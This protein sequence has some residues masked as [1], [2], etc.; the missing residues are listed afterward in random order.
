MESRDLKKKQTRYKTI[1]FAGIL[2]LSCMLNGCLEVSSRQKLPSSNGQEGSSMLSGWSIPKYQGEPFVELNGNQPFF[3]EE[4]MTT[5]AFEQYAPLDE[6]GRCGVAYANICKEIMPTRERGNIGPVRPSGW[7]TVKYSDYISDRYLYNRCHLIAF[8]LAG[9]NANEQNLITGTR[10][11][12]VAG[13]LPF[14]EKVANYID[15]TNHHVL[16]R[17]TPVFVKDNLVA[18]GVVMEAK[19]VEDQGKG[20]CFCVFCY[21][22]QPNIEID[23]A[24]GESKVAQDAIPIVKQEEVVQDSDTMTNSQHEVWVS[25][26]GGT[27]YHKKSDCSGMKNSKKMKE[28]IAKEKGYTPCKKC[29]D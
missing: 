5:T 14:E 11:F 1:L 21:N 8:C 3:S 4:E 16:Y 28:E 9:E 13:M 23:Y 18:S 10:Y 20:I 6:L 24:T 7:H 25:T 26:K 19:S 29:Y 15:E 22:V 12:N 2:L 27:K 17:V